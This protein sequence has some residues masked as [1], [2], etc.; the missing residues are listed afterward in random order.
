MKL[1]HTKD[2]NCSSCR[3]TGEV[4]ISQDKADGIWTTSMQCHCVEVHH[5]DEMKAF[6]RAITAEIDGAK[7]LGI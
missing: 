6:L 3:G 5:D 4:W 2:E 1:W 7:D